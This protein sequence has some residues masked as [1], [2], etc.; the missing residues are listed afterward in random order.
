VT[1]RARLL[2]LAAVAAAG[3]ALTAAASG[4]APEDDRRLPA[5]RGFALYLEHC[6]SCHGPDG[7]G[8]FRGPSLEGA[9]AAAAHFQVTTGRMPPRPA[10]R[11]PNRVPP[12][13]FTAAEARAIA[14]VVG[15]LGDGPPIPRVELRSADVSRGAELYLQ[16]CSA[17]HGS[18]GSGAALTLGREAPALDAVDPVQVAEAMI[19]G[20]G[21]MPVFG[22]DVF[23]ARARDAIVAY[24][25]VLQDPRDP[26]GLPLGRG[27]PVIEALVTLVV[28]LP[29]L[30]L[31]A[32]R[33]GRR[34]GEREAP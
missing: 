12:V 27:G 31:I 28:A 33:L 34:A 9:G 3:A 24:V 18:T 22:D 6:A 8:T 26:G 21:A 14:D 32:R 19:T 29:V 20:P 4:Q 16:A 1:A 15:A 10:D 30:L 13:D 23:D 17:C 2:H 5:G 25:G 11:G 7:A